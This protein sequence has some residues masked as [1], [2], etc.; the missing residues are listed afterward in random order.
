MR[1]ERITDAEALGPFLAEAR[2]QGRCAMDTEFVWERTYAPALC[3]I[4]IAT[5]DRLAVIDPVEGAPTAPVAELV[6]DP[7]VTKVMHAAVADLAAFALHHDVHPRAVW[8]T[9]VAAGFAGRGGSLSLER[10]LDAVLG[11]RLHHDEGFTDWQRR[12]LTETQVEYAADDVR[13]LL[14]AADALSARLDELGRRAWLDEELEERFGPGARIVQNPA[15]AWRRVAG[16][17]KLRGEQ[18]ATLVSIAE[19]REREARRRDIPAQWLVKDASLIEVARRRPRN[20]ADAARVRGLQLRKGGQLEGLL[21]AVGRAGEPPPSAEPELTSDLR[22]RVR[23]V[24][25]LASSVLQAR[26]AA[27]GIAS[28][29]VATRADLESLIVS[30]ARGQD[31]HPLLHGWRREVAGERLEQLLAGKVSLRVLPGPPHV[32]ES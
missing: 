30:A 1:I 20:A 19:W 15:D 26:C 24:L 29:L 5:A 13:H 6:A 17:G 4:Q 27:A 31:S 22:R 18:L 32:T 21:R 11:V 28:E 9:Q 8:D 2:T 23:V 14:A 7:A 10:L 12:P 16:R 25:P 3:L